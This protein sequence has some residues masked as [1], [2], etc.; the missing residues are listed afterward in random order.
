MN[1]FDP[2]ILRLVIVEAFREMDVGGYS[3]R[4]TAITVIGLSLASRMPRQ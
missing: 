1:N 4:Y 3:R 2:R